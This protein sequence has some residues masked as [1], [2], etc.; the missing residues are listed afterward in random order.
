MKKIKKIDS[1]AAQSI[2]S[3]LCP[4]IGTC[5]TCVSCGCT[6]SSEASQN[7]FTASKTAQTFAVVFGDQGAKYT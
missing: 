5:T 6:G 1:Q 7:G 3:F 4:C 2:F